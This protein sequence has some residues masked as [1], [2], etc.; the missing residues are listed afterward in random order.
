M[1][2]ST[3]PQRANPRHICADKFGDVWDRPASGPR[4]GTHCYAM[5]AEAILLDA[6]ELNMGALGSLLASTMPAE[7]DNDD[8][9]M[10]LG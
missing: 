10:V 3:C 8:C 5:P 4:P 7:D 1:N 9:G 6:K 2:D